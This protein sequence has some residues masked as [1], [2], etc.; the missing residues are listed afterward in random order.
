MPSHVSSHPLIQHKL[1]ILRNIKTSASDFRHVLKEITFYLGYEATRDLKLAQEEI[2]TPSNLT[3]KGQKIGESIAI[4]PILRAGLG[5]TDALLELMPY[6]NVHHLGSIK[7]YSY[8]SYVLQYDLYLGMY[9]AK[10]NPLPVQYYN[11]LPKDQVCDVAYIVDATIN[12]SNTLHA[13]CS[14]VKKWG[15]K[16]IIVISVIAG[17]GKIILV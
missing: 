3:F 13:A 4:I 5:M 2:I 11:R 10:H 17:K 15:A 8:T 1:T 14:I 16:K 7:I 9:R 6:S 12:T